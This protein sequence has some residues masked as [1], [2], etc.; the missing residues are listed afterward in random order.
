MKQN[1][2]C[3]VLLGLQW[4]DEGKAKIIN[5]LS[6]KYDIIVRFQ[7]GANAGHTV[8]YQG[9]KVVFHLIPS[10]LLN[11]K[12]IGII[13]N[14]V[15]F[16]PEVF[17]KELEDLK[18]LGVNTE[19]RIFISDKAILVLP[20]N[21]KI[22]SIKDKKNN[23]GTTKRGIGPTY[24]SK[25][26]RTGLKLFE[27]YIPEFKNRIDNYLQSLGLNKSDKEY[28]ENIEFINSYRDRLE[29]YIKVTELYLN[30]QL[31]NGK[32]ILFEGA[33][34]SGLDIDFGT[35]PYVTSSN[36]IVS[37]IIS[38]A[39][40]SYKS[41]R[42]VFGLFKAYLTRVGNG[43]FPTELNDTTGQLLREKGNEFGATTGRPR[44]CG[45]LDLTQVN[46]Y[47]KINGVTDLILSKADILYDFEKIY[48]C[49]DYKIKSK[50]KLQNVSDD[51]L[52]IIDRLYK[53]YNNFFPVSHL[54]YFDPVYKEFKGFRDLNSDSFKNFIDYIEKFTKIKISLISTGPEKNE[55]LD[56]GIMFSH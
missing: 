26:N 35:Y 51:E 28:I 19:S 40:V 55:F 50:D 53:E 2:Y 23:I 15:T 21:K 7:G 4:G 30:Q 18:N 44:R 36:T 42:K 29:Q 3:D 32:K 56:R 38:G 20:I 27:L 25:I 13:G 22:D 17:F 9:K 43:P 33:Q 39:G 8:I 37:S 11:P 6:D 14:G 52:M 47:A 54:E 1:G 49:I 10:S 45:W 12:T 24:S 46:Y 41:I 34:G 31:E 16:D 48:I 5:L